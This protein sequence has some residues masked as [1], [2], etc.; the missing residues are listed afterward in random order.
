MFGEKDRFFRRRGAEEDIGNGVPV[1]AEHR[2]GTNDGVLDHAVARV[3]IFEVDITAKDEL[4][5]ADVEIERPDPKTVIDAADHF[6]HLAHQLPVL[7]RGGNRRESTNKDRVVENHDP[8]CD[9]CD[10]RGDFHRKPEHLLVLVD[11]VFNPHP[12][13][14]LFD[15][16]E[17]LRRTIIAAHNLFLS[18]SQKNNLTAP[19]TGA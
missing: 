3:G 18:L 1:T 5:V 2:A 8:V 6:G 17:I 15:L 13:E 11:R 7:V 10:F 12:V 19:K 14:N 4:A 9:T 16:F